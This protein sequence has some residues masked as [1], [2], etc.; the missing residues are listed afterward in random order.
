MNKS[1]ILRNAH[2]YARELRLLDPSLHYS[3]ALSAGMK[4]AWA[5]A[6]TPTLLSYTEYM[7]AHFE[8]LIM[9]SFTAAPEERAIYRDEL[10]YQNQQYINYC[11]DI[12]NLPSFNADKPSYTVDFT[13]SEMKSA[14]RNTRRKHH[15]DMGGN[16][17][18]FHKLTHMVEIVERD[19]REA[20]MSPAEMHID[21]LRSFGTPEDEPE[22]IIAY[23]MLDLERSTPLMLP[24]PRTRGTSVTDEELSAMFGL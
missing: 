12:F 14:F 4:Q 3:L 15:P 24:A 10:R 21:I 11:C 9:P 18:N 8:P 7:K 2:T 22:M 17:D 20:F 5:E 6:K 19:S 23:Q 16:A 13:Q 1:T